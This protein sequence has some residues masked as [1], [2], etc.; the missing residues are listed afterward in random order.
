M[1]RLPAGPASLGFDAGST[2]TGLGLITGALAI[3]DSFLAVLTGTLA[4]IAVAAWAIERRRSPGSPVPR[5]RGRTVFALGALAVGSGLF[6]APPAGIAPFRALLLA[7]LLLPLWYDTRS[8]PA[9]R[10]PLAE[11]P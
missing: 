9:V 8:G 1:N 11:R 2:A 3:L 6:L 4:A 10:K 5:F 7:L